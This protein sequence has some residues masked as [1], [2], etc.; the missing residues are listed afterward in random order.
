VLPI[1]APSEIL[2][3]TREDS[4]PGAFSTILATDAMHPTL[5]RGMTVEVH[6]R[7]PRQGNVV[8]VLASARLT[9]RRVLD[10]RGGSFLLRADVAPFVDGWFSDFIGV[11]VERSAVSHMARR[12]PRLWTEGLW[13]AAMARSHLAA[14]RRTHRERA[15]FS[16]RVLTKADADAYAALCRRAY[17][18]SDRRASLMRHHV[19]LG[20]FTAGNLVGA[21]LL[22]PEEDHWLSCSTLV[23]PLWRGRGGGEVLLRAALAEARRRNELPVLGHV[24]ARNLASMTACRRAGLVPTGRWWRDP[25]DPLMA[26]ERQWVIVASEPTQLG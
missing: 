2:A 3:A 26:A 8:G 7:V 17:N 19:G 23:D 1:L 15:W 21:T 5:L 20:L 4:L 22:V 25:V 18:G 13:A 24:H 11:L 12:A 16:T 6:R 14:R 9:W 10:V